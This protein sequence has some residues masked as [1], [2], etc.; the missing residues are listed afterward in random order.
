MLIA[1]GLGRPV[2]E[3]PVWGAE[4]PGFRAQGCFSHT[5]W[6]WLVPASPDKLVSICREVAGLS[7]L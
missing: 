7:G 2:W 6:P 5:V 3:A 1:P 4:T